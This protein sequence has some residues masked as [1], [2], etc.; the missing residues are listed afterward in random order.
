MNMPRV[1]R[2]L[3]AISTACDSRGVFGIIDNE[4]KTLRPMIGN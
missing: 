2:T 4:Q 1:T 3:G